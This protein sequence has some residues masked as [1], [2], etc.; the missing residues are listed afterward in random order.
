MNRLVT[1]VAMVAAVM[2]AAGQASAVL[3]VVERTDFSDDF[4]THNVGD[5]V[6]AHANWTAGYINPG[7]GRNGGFPPGTTGGPHDSISV[8]TGDG[9]FSGN[10][11]D[12]FEKGLFGGYQG[13]NRELYGIINNGTTI[14]G[15][16]PTRA[17]KLTF[18][19]KAQKD[20]PNT[21]G[22]FF[23]RREPRTGDPWFEVSD[24]AD[25][26]IRDGRNFSPQT[27]HNVAFGFN[28]SLHTQFPSAAPAGTHI[29]TNFE[30]A[31]STR[32]SSP[33]ANQPNEI[34]TTVLSPDVLYTGE[35]TL[36]GPT[37]TA[38][39]AVYAGDNSSRNGASPVLSHN[40][41]TG[42]NVAGVNGLW[43]LYDGGLW[44]DGFNGSV[45]GWGSRSAL[46]IDN[47]L[48]TSVPEPVS[49]VALA[50]TSVIV[51]RREKR[52]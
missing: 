17:F 10:Y 15:L 20:G 47:V 2:I 41:F 51:L 31:G 43:M 33:G 14:S 28:T 44:D 24:G 11:M 35:I 8:G 7:Q 38:T 26:L 30:G 50:L 12:G 36:D 48:L 46:R 6:S 25:G 23:P 1:A 39:A 19:F 22:E 29:N 40:N 13:D 21:N 37:S 5:R 3:P 4:E 34:N 42:V 27:T 45:P 16:D 9:D 52:A 32:F 18:L 49:L